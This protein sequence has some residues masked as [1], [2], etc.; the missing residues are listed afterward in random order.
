[1]DENEEHFDVI[2]IGAGPAGIACAYSLAKEGK[3]VLVV[4]RGDE[5]GSKNMT[6][7][8]LYTYALEELEF[9]FSVK[10]KEALERMVVSEQMMLLEGERAVTIAYYDKSLGDSNETPLSYTII[11][12]KFDSWFASQAEELGAVIACGVH[13]DSL[14]EKD[15][16]VVGVKAGE[17]DMYADMVVAADGINSLIGQSIGLVPEIS[18][19]GVCV[20]AKETIEL[21]EG[22]IE[23]RFGCSPGEGAA[24]LIIG[25]VDGVNGGGIIYTNRDTVSLGCVLMPESLTAQNLSIADAVQMIKAHPAIAPLIEGGRTVEYSAHL[26]GEAGLKAIPDKLGKPGLILVGDAAGFCINQGYTVRGID[27]AI[28]SGIAAAR[29]IAIDGSE[30]SYRSELK[31]I[32]VNRAMEM[33]RKFPDIEEDPRIFSIYPELACNIFEA[34]YRID[35]YSSKPLLKKI[36]DSIKASTTYRGLFG[37]MKK[38]T[39]AIKQKEL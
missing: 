38:I 19:E 17:D 35:T 37:D 33:S 21:S 10:A 28:L 5:P 24:R 3:E 31:R 11:R 4:E 30:A 12:S 13:V 18:A 7:G 2:V 23:E 22:M 27:L 26:C 1:M 25:G 29:A 36:K 16:R 15:G 6:G 9:G 20:G 34:V 39:S 14:L 32:G 8:R